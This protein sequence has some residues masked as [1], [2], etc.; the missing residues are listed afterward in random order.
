M[1]ILLSIL[2]DNKQYVVKQ[3]FGLRAIRGLMFD[4]LMTCDGALLD[5]NNIWMPFVYEPLDLFFLDEAYHVLEKEEAV[6]ITF[7]PKTWRVYACPKA[8]YCLELK[9]GLVHSFVRI[10]KITTLR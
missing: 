9:H 8:K 7:D 6:P 5:G 4:S 3:C 10:E 1:M 2:I